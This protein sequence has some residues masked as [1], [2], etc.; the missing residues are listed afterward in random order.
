MEETMS[1]QHREAFALMQYESDDGSSCRLIWNSRDGVTPFVVTIDGV[2]YRHVRWGEDRC[3]PGY[4]VVMADTDLVFVSEHP[5]LDELRTQARAMVER[6]PEYAPPAGPDRDSLV[7]K[8]AKGM[9]EDCGEV[10][11][12]ALVTGAEWRR[13]T[14]AP[15]ATSSM[16]RVPGGTGE[17]A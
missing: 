1:Y 13:Q 11:R 12:P 8:V 10:G 14:G 6:A 9:M 3:V 7:E 15:S 4:A 16:G 5:S 2:E 17:F